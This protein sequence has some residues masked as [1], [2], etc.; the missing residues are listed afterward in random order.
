MT[1][2]SA[3]TSRAMRIKR[4]AILGTFT[5]AMLVIATAAVRP[6]TQTYC[7]SPTT[8]VGPWFLM[9]VQDLGTSTDSVEVATRASL[10]LPA[11][12]LANI[13]A[14]TNESKCLRA[15]R[16]IDSASIG[17]PVNSSIYL[18][19]VGTHYMAFTPGPRGYMVHLN[20]LFTVH[21]QMLQ[22]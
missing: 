18:V 16:A 12:T 2:S 7:F 4:G 21:G 9:Q 20:N 15:S 13:V 6:P 1:N 17:V 3:E 11:T 5:I 8:N 10:G 14:I 22:M 19:Q